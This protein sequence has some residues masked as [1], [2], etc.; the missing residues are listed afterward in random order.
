LVTI[1]ATV[2]WLELN[3]VWP[4]ASAATDEDCAAGAQA[5]ASVL[6]ELACG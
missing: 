6:A 2:I 3:E 5:L 1:W 4:K